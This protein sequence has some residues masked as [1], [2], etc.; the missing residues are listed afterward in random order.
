MTLL[1]VSLSVFPIIAVTS[2]SSFT[3]K[4][5]TLIVLANAIGTAIYV[6]AKRR[7]AADV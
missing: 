4:I 5:A 6:V 2:T 3:A 1:Y 7:R